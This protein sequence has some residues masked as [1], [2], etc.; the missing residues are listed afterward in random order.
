M[1]GVDVGSRRVG[2]A[3]ADDETRFA[4]PLEVV[5]ITLE[6]PI[7]RIARLC[8]DMNVSL[9]V[10][11]KPVGLAGGEGPA[12]TEQAG[13]VERLRAA[14]P[15]EVREYDERLTTVVAE[16]GMRAAGAGRSKRKRMRDAVAAQV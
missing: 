2:L 1:L 12:V 8:V 11:G 7:E 16:Q 5:D 10:V 9:V 14:V 6:D 4:R 13:F 3:V 15:V